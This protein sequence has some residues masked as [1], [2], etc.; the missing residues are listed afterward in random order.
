[1]SAFGPALFTIFRLIFKMIKN[2]IKAALDRNKFSVM[3]RKVIKRFEKNT[4][5]EATVWAKS[6]IRASLGEFC[7][8]V[9]SSLWA[10]TLVACENIKKDSD[11]ILKQIPC[12]L[13]A[14]YLRGGGNY[15]L[16]YFLVRKYRPNVVI[17]TGVAAGWSTKTISDALDKNGTGELYSSDFPYFR[18]ENP[19]KYIGVLVSD[20]Q[21]DKWKLDTRGDTLALPSFLSVIGDAKVNLFHYDSDKSYSGRS[22]AIDLIE[23]RFSR[24]AI[25]VVDDIQDNLH[26]RDYVRTRKLA[27]EVFEFEGKYV[28]LV[29]GVGKQVLPHNV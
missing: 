4:H 24:D 12:E 21:K 3:F 7:D 9:D 20:E 15:P 29:K 17:E 6:Q 5:S 8:A 23:P 13:V 18:I 11:A 26:F 14:R 25:F 1:M 27:Y 22:F 2:V 16:L 28:G 10:E 19:E